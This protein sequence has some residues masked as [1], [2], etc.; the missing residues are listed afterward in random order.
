M[1]ITK[2]KEINKNSLKAIVNVS[3][4]AKIFPNV[5]DTVELHNI[6]Y[7]VKGDNAWISLPGNEYEKDGKRKYYS[8]F[9]LDT[10]EKLEKFQLY[11]KQL[12]ED[13]T[14]KPHDDDI[15]F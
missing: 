10:L 4:Q 2:Y 7:F 11:L 3:F 12:I 1:Q 8:N 15:P 14:S 5:V 6:M 13:Y 9:R